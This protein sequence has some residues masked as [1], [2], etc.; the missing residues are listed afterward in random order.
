[1]PRNITELIGPTADLVGSG[2]NGVGGRT[3]EILLPGKQANE[4]SGTAIVTNQVSEKMNFNMKIAY[5][6]K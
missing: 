2:P 6:D 1:M 4:C 3:I 5:Q